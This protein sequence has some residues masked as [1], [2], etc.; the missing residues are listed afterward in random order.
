M[1]KSL[2]ELLQGEVCLVA[3]FHESLQESYRVRL[4]ELGFHPGEQVVCLQAPSLGA[5]R[6]YRVHDAVYSLD[7]HIAALVL[8]QNSTAH[9]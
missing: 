3:G 1:S 5:P 6:L 7:D 8:V 2:W 4:I 9:A